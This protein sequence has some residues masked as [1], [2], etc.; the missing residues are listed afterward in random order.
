MILRPPRSTRTYTLLPYTTLF[1]SH[2]LFR[3]DIG[4][5]SHHAALVEFDPDEMVVG[6]RRPFGHAAPLLRRI[7][8]DSAWPCSPS[9]SAS[10]TAA[11]PIRSSEE[12]GRAHV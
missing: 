12:I 11:G 9:A 5:T 4:R 7:D 3:F 10:R 1:R 8:T 6:R 2:P